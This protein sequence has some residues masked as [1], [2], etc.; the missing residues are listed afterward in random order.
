MQNFIANAIEGN[1]AAQEHLIKKV[2]N[3]I[4]N[5]AVYFT[6]D[7]HLAQDATQDILIKILDKLGTLQDAN[8]FENW[9]CQIASNYLRNL[10]RQAKQY[11]NISFDLME[12]D[13]K[14]HL[15]KAFEEEAEANN[16]RELAYEL[17]ISCTTAMLMCL[18]VEDRIV[19]ILAN[20]LNLNSQEGGKLL[21]ISPDLFRQRLS[22]AKKKLNHFIDN[23]CG[24][25]N[26]ENSCHCR[27]RVPY[28]ISQKRISAD[29]Y[30]FLSKEYLGA[31][32]NIEE[33]IIEMEDLEDLGEVYANN[34]SYTLPKEIV[35]KVCLI[36]KG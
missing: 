4:F 16:I 1:R 26:K 18:D 13:S 9:S 11:S 5:I 28:A 15:D 23:N 3:K 17:K 34:P 21:N 31:E 35:D 24:L 7:F 6:G 32:I 14:S 33:K 36:A 30:R 29:A 19:F 10:K 27:R 12:M 22:R 8:K 2:N 20:L 25:L